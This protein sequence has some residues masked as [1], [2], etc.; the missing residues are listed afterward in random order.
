LPVIPVDHL[1]SV[2]PAINQAARDSIGWPTYV[3]E[4]AAVVDDLPPEER[5]NAVLLT[6]NYGEAGALDRYGPALGLPPVYS[7]QNQLYELGPPPPGTVV[8]V[9][10]GLADLSSL[11]DSCTP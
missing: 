3:H 5:A 11:F 6:G 9:T 4:V 1:P 2:I 10:V 8:A 7:G